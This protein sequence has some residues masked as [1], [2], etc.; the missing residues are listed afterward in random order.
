MEEP[1]V[2]QPTTEQSPPTP[3]D[4]A[5]KINWREVRARMEAIEKRNAELERERQAL[6]SQKQVDDDNID[7]A[8]DSLA[9]GRHIKKAIKRQEKRDTETRADIAR[10]ETIIAKQNL[11]LQYKDFDQIFNETNIK[12]LADE[13]PFLYN[14]INSTKD[15]YEQGASAYEA[16]KSYVMKK[17]EYS[18][19]EKRIEENKLK[20]RSAATL[21]TAATQSPL[22]NFDNEGRISLTEEQKKEIRKRTAALKN[23]I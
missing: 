5:D 3:P 13:K 20:P 1:K 4:T 16:I 8:D 23:K 17:P 7:I 10:L 9:E 19:E 2:E 12:K 15:I 11:R 14:A 22:A 21:S 6:L 18:H